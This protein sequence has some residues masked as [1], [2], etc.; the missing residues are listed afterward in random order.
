[1]LTLLMPVRIGP[2]I[3]SISLLVALIDPFR[4]HCQDLGQSRCESFRALD[5][6]WSFQAPVFPFGGPAP[7]PLISKVFPKHHFPLVF[8]VSTFSPSSTPLPRFYSETMSSGFVF[9]LFL[10]LAEGSS[11]VRFWSVMQPPTPFFNPSRVP[12]YF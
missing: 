8:L 11:E 6:T 1:M 2:D 4:Y 3:R 9:L 12:P 10:S 7:E 5:T